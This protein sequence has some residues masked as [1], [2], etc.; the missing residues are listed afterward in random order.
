MKKIVK[1]VNLEWENVSVGRD[2]RREDLSGALCKRSKVKRE[3]VRNVAFGISPRCLDPAKRE[4]G[5]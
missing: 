1:L 3:K 5:N 2:R 4:E